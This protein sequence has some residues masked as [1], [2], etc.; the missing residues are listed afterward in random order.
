MRIYDLDSADIKLCE[1]ILGGV[2]RSVDFIY[3][4]AGVNRPLRSREEKPQDNLNNTL[5]R[6][7]VNKVANAISEI[8]QGLSTEPGHVLKDKDQRGM[9]FKTIEID[10][11]RKEPEKSV[12]PVIH[13]WLSLA[14]IAALLI[15][16]AIITYPKI[17][18]RDTLEKLRSSG[19]R[20]IVA[21]MP[22]Q[23]MTNDTVWNVWQE[24]IQDILIASLSNAEEL[25]VRQAESVSDLV[26]GQGIVN[27]ASITPSIA[28]SISKKLEAGILVYGS[29]KQAGAT[30]RLYAQLID[31]ETEEAYKSFQ[32]EGLD[33]EETIFHMIDSLS[34][35][36]K[37]FLI[38][39]EL[40]KTEPS[41]YGKLITTSSP[42]AY[43]YF[44][45]GRN[46]YAKSDFMA[47]INWFSKAIS[48]DSNFYQA[49]LLTSVAY[50]NQYEIEK[51]FSSTYDKL[52]LY[53]EAKKWC[54]RA[55]EKIDQM[56]VQLKINTNWTYAHCN[57]TPYDRIKYL[58]QLIET[59]D[60]Q[61][62]AL[63]NV[64]NCYSELYQYEKAIPYFE[65]ALEIYDKWDIKPFWVLNYVYLGQAYQRNGQYKI[66]AKIYKKAEQ[67]SPDDL[68]LIGW[69]GILSA[70][71]GDSLAATRYFEKFVSTARAMYVSEA[72][73]ASLLGFG[74]KVAGR[75]DEADQHYRIALSLEPDNPD[76][77]NDLA[78]F[79]IDT[80]RN[81]EEALNLTEQALEM[82]PN[83]FV[84]LD[85]KGW[86]LYKEGKY[87][88]ALELLQIS[89]DQR[90]VKAIYDHAA[91]LRLEAAKKA[92]AGQK[93]N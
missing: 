36:V 57:G 32:I 61:P 5:Y 81:I 65:K 60:L 19:K 25:K 1:T 84:Y 59:D 46:S 28:S 8:I 82:V 44:V 34:V 11:R 16:A 73:I 74:N 51:V 67:F 83:Y 12:K 80:D 37:D 86:G 40:R 17:F 20:I 38:L 4:S 24:G 78:F 3:K 53:E 10:D 9:S 64:G 62:I 23:N 41:F 88:A 27:F 58:M 66:A 39:T 56:P 90:M 21:V 85:T 91:F 2:L 77:I 87:Q 26:R 43:R 93:N 35:M 63:F 69:Q 6:D 30:A 52:Y 55:Y 76:R 48:I 50:S 72:A 71:R 7:Q 70:I 15:I 14:A 29:I 92:V 47:A 22:F 33:S 75:L 45:Q 42:E 31:P 18:K 54:L 49:I 79:L 13:R 89:W 68:E